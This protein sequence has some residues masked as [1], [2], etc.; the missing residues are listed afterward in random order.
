MLKLG[1]S[2]KVLVLSAVRG[3]RRHKRSAR[4][5]PLCSASRVYR[6]T[7]RVVSFVERRFIRDYF[8][9]FDSFNW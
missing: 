9:R 3:N 5:A 8:L 7:M 1:E 4:V 2:S 6:V